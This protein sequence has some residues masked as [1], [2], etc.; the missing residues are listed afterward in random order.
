MKVVGIVYENKAINQTLLDEGFCIIGLL[1]PNRKVVPDN[2]P[3][4]QMFLEK[5]LSLVDGVIL[6]GKSKVGDFEYK[7][8]RYA[9]ANNIPTLEASTS[10][11]KF[12]AFAHAVKNPR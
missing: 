8:A 2:S 4:E 12:K 1:P 5:Q 11:D 6:R 3:W 7:V 10:Q 9:H